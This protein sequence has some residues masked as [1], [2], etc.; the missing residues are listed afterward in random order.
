MDELH[1]QLHRVS[2]KPQ[3][4]PISGT[5]SI[6]LV[7]PIS[8]ILPLLDLILPSPSSQT[9][10][11]GV[12]CQVCGPQSTQQRVLL[13]LLSGRVSVG[14]ERSYNWC[15]R[16]RHSATAFRLLNHNSCHETVTGPS[17]LRSGIQSIATVDRDMNPR[18]HP[19]RLAR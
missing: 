8:S 10:N 15:V 4:G 18:H 7:H 6:S 13:D 5:F 17:L 11:L 19:E 12:V 9:Q 16:S 2:N 3:S 1:V 14:L